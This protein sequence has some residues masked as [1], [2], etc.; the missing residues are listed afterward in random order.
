MESGALRSRR[1]TD[2]STP[3]RGRA[4]ALAE[5]DILEGIDRCIGCGLC[6]PA[7][8]TYELARTEMEGPRGRIALMRAAA[9][10][11]VAVAGSFQRH[12]EHCLGCRSCERACPSGVEYGRLLGAARLAI[13]QDRPAR[14]LS[15]LFR[16]LAL[17]WL[18]PSPGRLSAVAGLARLAQRLGLV[19]LA[20]AV[21]GPVARLAS[22]LPPVSPKVRP[23]ADPMPAIG[24]PRGTVALF[25]GCIQQAFLGRV[26]EATVD[27]LRRNGFRVVF[28]PGQT[29]CGAAAHHLGEL[30]LARE[31]ARRNL[32]AF[33][34]DG[35]DFI[36]NNAGGC[37]ALAVL[38]A[39]GLDFVDLYPA[40]PDYSAGEPVDQRPTPPI[41]ATDALELLDE[42]ALT[43]QFCVEQILDGEPAEQHYPELFR[44]A[45][46]IGAIRGAWRRAPQ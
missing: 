44:V 23:R 34:P 25:Q 18:L 12:L 41:P 17:H 40:A 21:P 8:P 5:L 16:R 14:G 32:E 11:R 2:R 20:R 9:E 7:C 29:C 10:G 36:V 42:E 39:I 22:L 46:R 31:A 33:D 30:E 15:A 37:G 26:N 35:V 4:G 45:S 28:P 1:M 13:E 6:L 24:P 43:A 38:D 27:V 3:G 19:A